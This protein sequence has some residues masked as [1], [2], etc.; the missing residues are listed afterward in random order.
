IFSLNLATLLGLGLGIDYS[1]FMVSRFRE[2]LGHGKSVEEA[3]A[4]SIA[5]AGRAVLISGSTVAAGLL[6]LLVFEFNALW[7][8]G[9]AHHCLSFCSAGCSACR[10]TTRFFSCHE[11]RKHT[12]QEQ[13]PPR[14]SSAA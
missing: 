11:S 13:I 2:E 6:G 12:T 5:T 8:L 4:G 9:V 14:A 7:S 1:L 10:W 3:I